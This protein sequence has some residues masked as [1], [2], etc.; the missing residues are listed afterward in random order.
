MAKKGGFKTGNLDFG[1]GVKKARGRKPKPAP[2]VEEQLRHEPSPN[3]LYIAHPARWGIID[4]ELR[5]QLAKLKLEPGVGGITSTGD[6]TLARTNMVKKGWIIIEPDE[7]TGPDGLEGYV[8]AYDGARGTIH[9][10][11]WEQPLQ[12]GARPII[13][14]DLPGYIAF[15]DWLVDSGRIPLP[16]PEILEGLSDIYT[17]RL[18]EVSKDA[19]HN[20]ESKAKKADYEERLRIIEDAAEDGEPAPVPKGIPAVASEPAEPV[21]PIAKHEAKAPAKKRTTRR[22]TTR[23]APAR[24][25]TTTKKATT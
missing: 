1:D 18:L 12:V 7:I 8:R 25:R 5:P 20:P 11:I 22:K 24:K 14:N 16:E 10:S 21:P 13:R 19:H 2:S 4:G 15:L 23:K 3:F 9:L 17:R 6:D